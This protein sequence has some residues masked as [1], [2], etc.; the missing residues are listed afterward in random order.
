LR[1]GRVI[2]KGAQIIFETDN[3]YNQIILPI[4]L[5]DLILLCSG[6]FSIRQIIEKFYKKRGTVPFKSILKAI[7]ALH[8][9]G[10]F[11]NGDELSLNPYLQSWMEPRTTRPWNLSWRFGQR[12]MADQHAP[13]VFYILTLLL[14]AGSMIGMQELPLQ[15]MNLVQ[16]L[17]VN[18]SA[19]EALFQL[20]ICSSILQTGRHIIR[21]IQLLLLTGKAYN[22][23]LRLS[24]WG[25]HLHVGDEANDLFE[26][27]LYTSM[28]HTSQMLVGWFI[29]FLCEPALTEDWFKAM[30]IVNIILTFWEMNPFV[31]SEG[32]RLI[33]S[34][35]LGADHEVVSWHYDSDSIFKL[36]GSGFGQQDRAFSRICSAWG[37]VW[38]FL[39]LAILCNS[40]A[41]FSGS[42]MASISAWD[43]NSYVALIG[44]FVWFYSLYSLSQA[45][46]EAIVL[47]VMRPWWGR[48]EARFKELFQNKQQFLSREE[49][50]ARIQDLPLFSHFS[51]SQL[52]N[53]LSKTEVT[54]V[55]KNTYI[56]K[57]GEVS[58]EFYVLLDG[59]IEI[60]YNVD[61]R[62]ELITSMQATA[63][64]GETS[65]LDDS[66]RGIQVKTVRTSIILE[67]P[68]QN[69]R[70][71]AQESQAIRQLEDFRNAI[72]VNQ[73]FAS[74]PV[75]RS[76]SQ[77]SID[78]LC[79]RGTLEYF[80][81]DQ[82]VF[83]QGDVGDSIYLVLRGSV[84]VEVNGTIVTRPKHGSFFGEISL[85]ANIPRTATVSCKEP[86][87]FFRISSDAF[88][89]VLVQNLDLGVFIE[90]I[91]ENRLREDLKLAT[92]APVALLPTGSDPK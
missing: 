10:F 50:L 28:F 26:N 81:Q 24:P 45:F 51:H 7:H 76:L 89:E 56:L 9:N 27:R 46:V 61:Q 31:Q 23:A 39:A 71:A 73:F 82:I 16:S 72:L 92:L 87:V 25:F 22:V 88:W 47:S 85:I 20:L 54:A 52:L 19:A 55:P 86:S 91:S 2:P 38:L 1:P 59:E 17:F 4:S 37:S 77:P 8:Q 63:I 53:I 36:L 13:S 12:I 33:R 41:I 34:L 65:L 30:T 68:V 90:T 44:T 5:A 78:F 11:E 15:P 62:D 48:V 66:P 70:A 83:R 42:V 79:S 80:D 18:S 6:Q 58:R 75:F 14:L 21:G 67:F 35:T 40:A 84:E 43:H 49:V 60:T 29:L 32:L 69:V 74:S 3:P 57:P 64:F